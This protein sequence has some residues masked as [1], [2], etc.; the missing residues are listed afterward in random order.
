MGELIH[1]TTVSYIVLSIWILK[2]GFFDSFHNEFYE[3][4]EEVL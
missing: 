2:N 1:S 3:K 4:L